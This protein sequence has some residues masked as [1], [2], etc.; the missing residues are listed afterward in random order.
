MVPFSA[1]VFGRAVVMPNLKP[2]VRSLADA[3]AYRQRILAGVP[4][5]V[6]FEPLMTLYLTGALRALFMA[7]E[8]QLTESTHADNTTPEDIA[9]A[10]ASGFVAACKYYPA[11]ATTNSAD[12][13]T[14]VRKARVAL[15]TLPFCLPLNSRNKTQVTP[16]LEAMAA[17]G[18]PL[19]VHGE[20]TAAEVDIFDR[21]ARF[22][23]DVLAPLI[24]RVTSLR[25]VVEH[26]TTRQ[27]VDF[28]KAAPKGRVAATVTPQHMLLNRNALLVG[29]VRP[30]YY[31]LPIL[32]REVHRCVDRMTDEHAPMRADAPCTH[33]ASQRCRC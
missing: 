10:A 23:E 25:V 2:P 33:S 4:P 13:V 31:C 6:A 24:D 17:A 18:M 32:K 11:G 26:I 16:A 27:A 5:G 19:L 9:A 20:V 3:T 29:G 14:D 21:E 7:A 8:S 30:H 12:G 22:L 15:H 28:V 1:R